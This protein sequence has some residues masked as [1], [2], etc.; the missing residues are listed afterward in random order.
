M[1]KTK[2]RIARGDEAG[3]EVE[4]GV[5]TGAT[6][7]GTDGATTEATD[8][9]AGRIVVKTG[10]LTS[11]GE[12]GTAAGTEEETGIGNANGNTIGGGTKTGTG[13]TISIEI[14]R[15]VVDKSL[16]L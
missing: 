9:T 15:E 13:T 7:I 1:R 10:G 4:V 3:Q 12:K 5:A 11:N 14:E 2:S 16:S 8:M 6:R